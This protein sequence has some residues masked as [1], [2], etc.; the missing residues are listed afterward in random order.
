MANMVRT[1]TLLASVALGMAGAS[2][3]H[4]EYFVRPVLQYQGSLV[5]G[6]IVDGASSNSLTYYDSANGLE[7]HVDL[8]EGTIR[9]YLERYAPSEA[10]S[11]ATGVMGDQIRY[12]G[13]EDVPVDFYFDFHSEVY[14][15][16][17]SVSAADT[18]DV[19]EI[20]DSRYIAIQAY[21]AVYEAGSGAYWADWTEFGSHAADALYV[22]SSFVEFTGYGDNF[23]EDYYGSLGT[24]LYLTSGKSYDIFAAFNLIVTPGSSS[25]YIELNGLNTGTIG[26]DAPAG[27]F[28]SQ[29]GSFLGYAQTPAAV[30]EPATWAMLVAGFGLIGGSMRQR[31]ALRVAAMPARG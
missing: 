27:D 25:G 20:P 1:A 7:A 9:T 19:I 24:Q 2:A 13:A 6:L 11:I 12:T 31:R 18:L 14:A 30:P 23:Y 8:E 26:I 5:D 28:T 16:L 10:F 15:D 17:Y 22:D 3:A 4:A 29:S 21:F